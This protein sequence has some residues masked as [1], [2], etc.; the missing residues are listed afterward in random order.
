[1]TS[2]NT[3]KKG[4]FR[5]VLFILAEKSLSTEIFLTTGT[6]RMTVQTI[7]ES[8]QGDTGSTIRRGGEP[9]KKRVTLPELNTWKP[10]VSASGDSRAFKRRARIPHSRSVERGNSP[11]PAGPRKNE[12]VLRLWPNKGKKR[13]REGDIM[14]TM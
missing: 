3:S 5:K 13:S 9:K 6:P 11:G 2:D 7:L 8:S 10:V 14:G 12:V 1:M 4:N